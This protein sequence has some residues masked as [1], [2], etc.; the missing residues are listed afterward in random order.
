MPGRLVSK[1]LR[2]RE[3]FFCYCVWYLTSFLKTHTRRKN[4][5]SDEDCAVGLVCWYDFDGSGKVP[6]CSGTAQPDAEYCIDPDD[7]E[8]VIPGSVDDASNKNVNAGP[9][10]MEIGALNRCE[11]DW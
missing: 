6:G 7:V 2:A 1:V 9:W 10:L 5:A 8:F 11:G 4:S 3:F